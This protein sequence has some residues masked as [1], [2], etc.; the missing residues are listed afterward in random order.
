[1]ADH[2]TY[3]GGLNCSSSAADSIFN[4][5]GRY[6]N[7]KSMVL[8]GDNLY[9]RSAFGEFG[10]LSSIGKDLSACNSNASDPPGLVDGDGNY[11]GRFSP[12]F[13]FNPHYFVDGEIA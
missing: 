5:A 7:C 8:G 2:K 13:P 1:V 11:Y 9:C 4:K 3:L 10:V 6:G 12:F